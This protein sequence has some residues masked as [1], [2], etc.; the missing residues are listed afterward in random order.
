[1]DHDND[2]IAEGT[3]PTNWDTDGDWMVDWFEVHDD[4]ED[5]IRGDSSPIRYDSRQTG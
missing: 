3:D 4:E 5:G 2:H 1:L